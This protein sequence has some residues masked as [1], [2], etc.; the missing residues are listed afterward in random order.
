MVMK[1]NKKVVQIIVVFL[2]VLGSLFYLYSKGTYTSYETLT[3]GKI[4]PKIAKWNIKVDGIEVTTSDVV[5]IGLSNITWVSNNAVNTKA[6]P[7]SNGKATV[8]IDPMDSDVAIK[9]TLEVIDRNVDENKFLEI[10]NV[11]NSTD[12]LIQTAENT[13]AGII[14]LD[15]VKN[16]N[17]TTLTF[18]VLWPL[19]EDID[20]YS[21][22][23]S[24]GSNFLEINFSVEQYNGEEITPFTTG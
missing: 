11:N 3:N 18:D 2:V 14:T 5:T 17:I 8:K 24:S 10:S 15:D 19:G 12:T 23:V 21:E 22:K 1:K 9:Y 4:T 16:K 20:P 7:G 13:Y 6:V